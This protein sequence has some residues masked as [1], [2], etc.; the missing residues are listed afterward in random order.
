MASRCNQDGVSALI[1]AS[2]KGHTEIVRMLLD[3][4]ADDDMQ[5]WVRSSPMNFEGQSDEASMQ[6]LAWG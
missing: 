6:A 5:D 1:Q 4:D 3:K 2:E